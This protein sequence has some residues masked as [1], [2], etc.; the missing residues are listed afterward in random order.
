MCLLPLLQ[1]LDHLSL[2]NLRISHP[3]LLDMCKTMTQVTLLNLQGVLRDSRSDMVLKT[4]STC[5][6]QLEWLDISHSK[7]SLNAIR[8]L[9]PT[10]DAPE[11]GCP[12]LVVISLWGIKNINVNFLKNIIISL[13][14]LTHLLHLLMINV[15][16][17]LT[18]EEACLG[19]FKC[20]AKLR[21][22]C[23]ASRDSSSIG[24]AVRYDI[25]QKAPEFASTCN[26]TDVNVSLEGHSTISLT[27][28]L[29]PLAKLDSVT[30]KSLSKGHKGLLTVLESKGNQLKSLHLLDVFETINL[31]DISR[32]C[33]YLNKFTMISAVS[34]SSGSY[35]SSDVG[36]QT[37][38]DKLL[39]G[40]Y[41]LHAISLG[42]LSKKLCSRDMMVALLVS[43]YLK[44][45]NLTDVAGLDDDVMACVQ[46]CTP[47]GLSTL[48]SVE[49]ICIEKCPNI[50]TTAFVRLLNTEGTMLTDLS[51][52]N[53]DK[54]DA[55]V[56]HKAVAKYPRPL[57]V[58]VSPISPS[59]FPGHMDKTFQGPCVQNCH[60]CTYE[61]RVRR[62][63]KLY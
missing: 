5:M 17:E 23:L 47:Y 18:D 34:F 58:T 61:R 57:N 40:L 37:K 50:T 6:P 63:S 44:K 60:Y 25:L 52:K 42:N 62:N 22:P 4:I 56:L 30:L 49:N 16:A 21:L 45:I 43:P 46:R 20:L 12:E 2:P 32:T 10:E 35:S 33:P 26:I 54:I 59:E 9:L 48:T 38:D 51:I 15:L 53:C 19:S 41:H 27:D 28:L 7:V 36:N 39:Y 13:P 8:Y 31:S 29:M 55:D 14:K 1:K 11:Q 24:R 3:A